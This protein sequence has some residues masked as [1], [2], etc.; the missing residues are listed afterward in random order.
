MT[1]RQVP[2]ATP[3]RRRRRPLAPPRIRRRAGTG[4]DIRPE[5]SARLASGL[6]PPRR[7][8]QR[9]SRRCGVLETEVALGRRSWRCRGPVDGAGRQRWRKGRSSY[10]DQH[11]AVA[12]GTSTMVQRTGSAAPTS[13]L[14]RSRRRAGP[15]RPARDS[16]RWSLADS[17]RSY[18]GSVSA[19]TWT[20]H[21][22]R[23][24]ARASSPGL[25]PL[26][27]SDRA[28]GHPVQHRCGPAGLVGRHGPC[29]RSQLS[30]VDRSSPSGTRRADRPKWDE[31][32]GR[33]A[34]P[35]PGSRRGTM[36]S[37]PQQTG[38]R[39]NSELRPSP[40]R[41]FHSRSGRPRS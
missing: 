15:C 14:A 8:S 7:G 34:Q 23:R 4:S 25:D 10:C 21:R 24:K 9:R 16:T 33:P 19:P 35:R 3:S 2:D 5:F 13:H 11:L 28:A 12:V 6:G 31:G 32:L 30:G 29:S 1:W 18:C 17:R 20:V 38:E 41:W 39:R 36:R 37:S 26:R 40:P 22:G 27:T